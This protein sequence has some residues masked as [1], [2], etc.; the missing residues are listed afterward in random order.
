MVFVHEDD[1]DIEDDDDD[2]GILKL[3]IYW[4]NIRNIFPSTDVSL[5]HGIVVRE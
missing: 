2:N 5:S 1:D 3:R 4:D